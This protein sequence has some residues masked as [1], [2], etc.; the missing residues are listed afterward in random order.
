MVW[1][2]DITQFIMENSVVYLMAN[3]SVYQDPVASKKL[4]LKGAVS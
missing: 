2:L 1:Q 3:G 4:V